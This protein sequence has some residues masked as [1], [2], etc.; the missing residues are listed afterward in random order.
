MECERIEKVQIIISPTKLRMKLMGPRHCSKKEGSNVMEFA[1]NSLLDS[2]SDLDSGVTN[3]T[4]V[5]DRTRIHQFRKGDLSMVHPTRQLDDENPDYD[6]NASSPSFEFPNGGER[7]NCNP[8]PSSYPRQ[9]PSKWNDAEKWIVNRQNSVKNGSFCGQGNQL[10]LRV[11]PEN[12]GYECNKMKAAADTEKV[13]FSQPLVKFLSVSP[14]SHPFPDRAN[15]ENM[16]DLSGTKNSS[17]AGHGVRS[18]CMRDMGTEMTPVASQEPSRTATPVGATTPLLSPTS[19]LP[20]TPRSRGQDPFSSQDPSESTKCKQSEREIKLRTR[21]EIVALG[22]QLGRTNIATWASK[23]DEENVKNNGKNSEMEEL[24]R[25]EHEKWAALWEEAEKSKHTARYKR[26]EINI[27]AWESQ[28]KSKLEAERRRI[29]AKVEK[30]KAEAEAKMVK[31][32]AMARQRSE[33]K[34]AEAEARK[35]RE[36]KK[37]AARAEYSR[38]IGR[39]RGSCYRSCGWFS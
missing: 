7:Y 28:E 26:E 12:A 21:R 20:S 24:Q 13:G 5:M 22:V 9:I 6:S 30:M 37:T 1:K 39:T 35:N 4:R 19:S 33:E 36:A 34:R 23:E 25:I 10:P 14:A 11:A 2:K 31:K 8:G 18:V 16:I 3:E 32:I 29:E 17:T 15:G 38:R 27:Q